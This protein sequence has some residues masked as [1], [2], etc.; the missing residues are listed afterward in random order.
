MFNVLPRL[1]TILLHTWHLIV[2]WSFPQP[3]RLQPFSEQFLLELINPNWK[4]FENAK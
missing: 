3:I 2:R 1:S 4:Y